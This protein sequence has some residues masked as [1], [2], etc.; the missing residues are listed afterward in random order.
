MI[1][2][3]NNFCAFEKVR[4]KIITNSGMYFSA[5]I[6]ID[7]KSLNIMHKI[8]KSKIKIFYSNKNNVQT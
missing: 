1:S 3:V 6:S 7:V 4:I 2:N 8:F 5:H